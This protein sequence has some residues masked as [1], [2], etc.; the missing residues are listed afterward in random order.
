MKQ[1]SKNSVMKKLSY[2]MICKLWSKLLELKDKMMP[3]SFKKM[4]SIKKVEKI[5][6]QQKKMLRKWDLILLEEVLQNSK[7]QQRKKM[8][9]KIMIRI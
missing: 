8:L 9:L 4:I 1:Y 6:K 5:V 7:I 3:L 2:I